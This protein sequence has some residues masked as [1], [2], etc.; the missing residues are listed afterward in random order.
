MV[1]KYVLYDIY[2]QYRSFKNTNNLKN[3]QTKQQIA[4]IPLAA[5]L[6]ESATV[7]YYLDKWATLSSSSS[8]KSCDPLRRRPLRWQI[9]ECEGIFEGV[10]G[11]LGEGG[12]E[13][14]CW[15]PLSV[16]SL[17]LV[18]QWKEKS[19]TRGWLGCSSELCH[20]SNWTFL[21][22]CCGWLAP[23]LAE[24]DQREWKPMC[25]RKVYMC[26]HVCACV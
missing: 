20:K 21:N 18:G 5:C 14:L 25:L 13:W 26:V 19:S 2:F 1:S 7:R 12:C 17:V 3:K 15:H 10:W 8:K 6:C 11:G 24:F 23:W 16:Q 22:I 4:Q 9:L